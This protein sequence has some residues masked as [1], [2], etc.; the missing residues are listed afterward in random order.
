MVYDINGDVITESRTPADRFSEL[1][2]FNYQRDETSGAFYTVL[3]VPMTNNEGEKQ[4]PFVIW[5]NYPNGGIQSAMQMNSVKKYLVAVNGG[6]YNTPYGAGVTLTG[7]P[8]G[9][10]IQNSVVLQQGASGNYNS[11]MDVVLT[12]NSNGR[13]GYADPL[14]SAS[15]L[16]SNGIVSAVTGFV[17][18]LSGY[19]NIE[20]VVD[21]TPE[22]IGYI[23]REDDT[24]HQIIGQYD[25]G[26]YA[27]ITTEARDYQ[28]GNWFTVKQA[29]TLCKQLGLKD[30]FMLDG[31]GSTETVVGQRQLNP[32]Y[33]NTL[34]RVNPT[35]IVFNGT[36]MFDPTA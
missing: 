17:P 9:T 31:G 2:N 3:N 35:F 26:D 36:T 15:G 8:K 4:Y 5:P 19:E 21:G 12:I 29:Q 11:T 18:I 32:F 30:A 14:D 20:D 23:D 25:N 7:L 16:V 22:W 34:G 6:R 13:L 33:D 1:I 28:G 10:V 27:I 24:Q